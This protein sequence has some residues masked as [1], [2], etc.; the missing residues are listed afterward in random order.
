[1]AQ[2]GV[3]ADK[4]ALQTAPCEIE[5]QVKIMTRPLNEKIADLSAARRRKVSRRNCGSV[6]WPEPFKCSLAVRRCRRR[7]IGVHGQIG[8]G[9]TVSAKK[10]GGPE[11][12]EAAQDCNELLQSADDDLR[13]RDA[14]D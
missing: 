13:T 12:D 4:R 11:Y 2:F 1:V 10:I 6:G 9:T 5:R 7:A 3:D 14:V 8:R